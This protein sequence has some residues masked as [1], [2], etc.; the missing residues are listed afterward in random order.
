MCKVVAVIHSAPHKAQIW[1]KS[2]YNPCFRLPCLAKLIGLSLENVPVV[3]SSAVQ[4][5]SLRPAPR[6]VH[7]SVT[8]DVAMVETLRVIAPSID[9]LVRRFKEGTR[10]TLPFAVSRQIMDVQGAAAN[11]RVALERRF[12]E[13]KHRTKHHP[14]RLGES[15][16][17]AA[18]DLARRVH[19]NLWAL[20]E[21]IRQGYM[22]QENTVA[23]R[24]AVVAASSTHSPTALTVLGIIVASS[25]EANF[26]LSDPSNA[27]ALGI[28]S[29]LAELSSFTKSA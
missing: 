26:D 29:N 4:T 23:V 27:R 14:E 15:S 17:A 28:L 9:P 16:P 5:S 19:R 11:A 12:P 20:E 10:N 25:K 22:K 7:T 18:R 8:T 2:F 24:D 6:E 3:M 13:L 1:Q 21:R